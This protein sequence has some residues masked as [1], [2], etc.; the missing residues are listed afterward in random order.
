MNIN[1]ILDSGKKKNFQDGISLEKCW[2]ETAP[3]I[4]ICSLF[5]SVIIK[6]VLLNNKKRSN[7]SPSLPALS[8]AS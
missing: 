7:P 2:A 3:L 4:T 1:F 5:C 6:Y 8:N